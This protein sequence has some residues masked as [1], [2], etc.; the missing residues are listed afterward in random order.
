MIWL[1]ILITIIFI[2]VIV[3][4]PI[5]IAEKIASI[6]TIL[7]I[8]IALFTVYKTYKHEEEICKDKEETCNLSYMDINKLFNNNPYN[9]RI[10]ENIYGLNHNL[11]ELCSNISQSIENTILYYKGTIIPKEWYII[12]KR[13]ISFPDFKLYWIKYNDE[14]GEETKVIISN[15]LKID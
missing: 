3:F 13:W 9:Q 11:V 1:I 7:Y 12:W 10:Y 4:L 5:K 8:S 14:F 2:I 15:L 6:L